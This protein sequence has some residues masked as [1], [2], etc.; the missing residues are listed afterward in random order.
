MVVI[1]PAVM[2]VFG[3]LLMKKLLW[4]LADEVLDG[5]DF[6]IVRTRNQEERVPLSN[7]MNVSTSI[8]VNPPRVTLRLIS[9]GKFGNEISFSPATP[10]SFNLFA[11]NVVAEDLIIRVHNAKTA[12]PGMIAG[13]G[14]E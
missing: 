11:R 5:G 6:L 2:A 4:D 7:I 8:L 14:H 13:V 9:P 10:F 12:R 1:V 3:Y